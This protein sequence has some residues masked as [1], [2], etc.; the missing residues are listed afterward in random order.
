MALRAYI[1]R[2]GE[3]FQV[4]RSL[5]SPVQGVSVASGQ[6]AY[7]LP[8][9]GVH[10]VS[11]YRIPLSALPT[12][13]E[14]DNGMFARRED[15]ISGE[16]IREETPIPRPPLL[17]AVSVYLDDDAYPLGLEYDYE[18]EDAASLVWGEHSGI[19][20]SYLHFASR[21]E[22]AR[23]LALGQY[24]PFASAGA[25]VILMIALLWRIGVL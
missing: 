7:A 21:S 11:A 16:V 10:P 19:Y 12:P 3:T 5:T 18:G 8:S 9:W 17:D 14:L 1:L 22:A 25:F 15:A 4:L 2:R 24:L 6:E 23:V 20:S 13:S